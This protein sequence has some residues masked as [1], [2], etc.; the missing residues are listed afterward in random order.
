MKTIEF[1]INKRPKISECILGR[2]IPNLLEDSVDLPRALSFDAPMEKC[3]I[4]KGQLR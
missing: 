1:F 2:P 4:S 3:R